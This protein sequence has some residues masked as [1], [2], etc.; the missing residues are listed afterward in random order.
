M[1]TWIEAG[2]RRI[3][4]ANSYQN[5]HAVGQA[6]ALSQVPRS[7]FFLL[8]KV[9]PSL[10]LG[11]N[12]TLAQFADVK[13]QMGV[14]YVDMLLVHWPVATVSQGNVTNNATLSSDPTCDYT[15]P[16]YNEKACRLSTWRAMV[17][18]RRGAECVCVCVYVCVEGGGG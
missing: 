13:A 14:S 15:R 9:G 1:L 7:E 16:T 4:A 8:S 5:H 17:Q 6:M 11:F 2:G 3:D 18:V 10:P 12:D